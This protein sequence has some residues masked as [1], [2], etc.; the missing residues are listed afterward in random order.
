MSGEQPLSPTILQ[1]DH[2]TTESVNTGSARIDTFS[3]TEIVRLMNAEDAA[4]VAAVALVADEIALAV[5]AVAAAFRQGGR[6]IYMGAGTSGRLGVLDASE[7]PPTFG[8]DPSQVVGLIAGGDCALRNPVEGAEDSPAQGA[9]DLETLGLTSRDIVMGIATSG[10]TPYVLGGMEY[11]RKTGC[12]TIGFACNSP[13]AMDTLADI[14]IAPIVGPEILS[15]S[16]RLKAGTA[17]KL[18]LNTITTGAMI[19]TGKT[20]GN[21][22]VDLKPLNEKLRIRSRRI[23][24]DIA[25][26]DDDT[27]RRCLAETSG[28]LKPA[29]VMA[30]ADVDAI[31]AERLLELNHGLVR[32]AVAAA[33]SA[34]QPYL[35]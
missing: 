24:R 3:A 22:M 11:A 10:R 26:V 13:S 1:V 32:L 5:D 21:R 2:L 25:G 7:C 18:V 9:T 27:A 6:L 34:S 19:R 17:T 23:L 4:T 29:L 30:L 35:K 12:T 33:S 28:R 14:M 8:T 31:Q 15:G 16:T 20:Y